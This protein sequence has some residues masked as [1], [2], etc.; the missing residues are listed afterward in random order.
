MVRKMKGRKKEDLNFNKQTNK[1]KNPRWS[2]KTGQMEAQ[3][4]RLSRLSR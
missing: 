1:K 4:E 2:K 3:M